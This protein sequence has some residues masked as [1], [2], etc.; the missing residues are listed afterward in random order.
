MKTLTRNQMVD[1]FLARDPAFELA[2]VVGVVTTGIY[3]VPTCSARKPKEKN[4]RFFAS[5]SEARNAG[6]RACKRCKPDQVHAGHDPEREA[7]ETV[8][9]CLRATPGE[10]ASV[11]A[12]ARQSGVGVTKLGELVRTHY[13]VTPR[14]LVSRARAS[15][16]RNASW[17]ARHDGCCSSGL[18]RASRASQPF[19]TT[20]AP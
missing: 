14:A 15:S 7:L 10:F 9:D 18:M 2:F 12:L 11:S 5:L 6:L 16:S 20:F 13:H 8:V 19:T 1:R 17:C 4:V 3:C